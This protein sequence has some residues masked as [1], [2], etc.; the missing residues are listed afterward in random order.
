MIATGRTRELRLGRP[1]LLHPIL[2]QLRRGPADP[3]HRQIGDMWL[4]ATRTPVGTALLKVAAS[5]DRVSARAWGEGAE[6]VL[7]Q[8]PR[9][10]GEGDQA[11]SFRPLPE[12]PTLVQAQRRF[13]DYRIGRSDAVFESLAP[14]CLEQVVTGKE[15]YLA[16]RL[17]VWE[18]GE[19]APGPADDPDSAAYGMR[20]AP[21]PQAWA[22][23]PSW[24][25]LAAGVE[26]RRSKPLVRSAARA[27][28]LERTLRND[29]A[30]AD[31]ALR[32]MPGIGPWTSAEV[33]QRAHGDAD[34]WS[35]GD[36]HVGKA[37]SW[38]LTGEKLDDDATEQI[39]EPYRGHRFRVQMLLLMAGLRPPRRGPR[40]TLPTHTPRATRG[41]S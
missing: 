36:Y 22:K 27:P 40:M 2:G 30:S 10:L 26:E 23:I 8:L 14:A 6:W 20:V 12:H 29:N 32:S 33:R 21:A 25:Y 19:L 5:G 37:I 39:L 9:L 15:A 11:D 18:F 17:L 41:S 34:A 16:F 7:E 35:I 28:A 31:R 1:V 13:G 3:T 4:R 24:R 38:A